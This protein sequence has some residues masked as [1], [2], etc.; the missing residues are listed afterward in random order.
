MEKLI[1]L[2]LPNELLEKLDK[3]SND[4]DRSRS[5]VVRVAIETFINDY[6]DYEI[7]IERLRDKNDKIITSDELKKLIQQ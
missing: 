7:A 5:Y 2:R 1:A 3:V 6:I 4:L